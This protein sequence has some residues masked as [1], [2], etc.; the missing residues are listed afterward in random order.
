MLRKED[1]AKSSQLAIDVE[2][3]VALMEDDM[4]LDPN[5]NPLPKGYSNIVLKALYC[6]HFQ[7]SRHVQW[8]GCQ[9]YVL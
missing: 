5:P 1:S 9:M 2:L 6:M 8:A 3:D 7:F 4:I